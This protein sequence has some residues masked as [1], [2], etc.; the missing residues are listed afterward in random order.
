MSSA[1]RDIYY[2]VRVHLYRDYTRVLKTTESGIGR[3]D[4]NLLSFFSP[5]IFPAA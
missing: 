5:L 1:L 2:I 3:K 4:G